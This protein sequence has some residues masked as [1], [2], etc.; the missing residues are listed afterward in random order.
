MIV[1]IREAL[2][3]FMLLSGNKNRFEVILQ[4]S[5]YNVGIYSSLLVEFSV[6]SLESDKVGIMLL[7]AL[8][9]FQL[10]QFLLGN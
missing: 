9:S 10:G 5:N 4:P 8:L 7:L 6:T 3:S 2:L 1:V